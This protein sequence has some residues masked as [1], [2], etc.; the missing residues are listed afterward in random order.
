MGPCEARVTAS[1]VFVATAVNKVVNPLVIVCVYDLC[2][3][4]DRAIRLLLAMV[5]SSF[6]LDLLIHLNISSNVVD[7]ISA[8]MAIRDLFC[9][10][11]AGCVHQLHVIAR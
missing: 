7:I 11:D 5:H 9:C 2:A 10:C 6:V 1:V 4:L 3:G 8:V